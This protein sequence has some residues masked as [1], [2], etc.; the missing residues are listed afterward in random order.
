MTADE[1]KA[2]RH[3]LGLTQAALAEKIGVAKNSVT[4]WEIGVR[5]VNAMAATIIKA[6]MDNAEKGKG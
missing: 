2:A 6:M 1:F 3:K 4:R 5:P